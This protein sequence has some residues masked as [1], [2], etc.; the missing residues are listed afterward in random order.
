MLDGDL[1]GAGERV[2]TEDLARHRRAGAS[3]G[4]AGPRALV[5]GIVA[6]GPL[7]SVARVR[8]FAALDETR[9]PLPVGPPEQAM[10]D[11]FAHE[12]LDCYRLAVGV[13]RWAAEQVFPAHRR[14]LRDQLVRA[15]DSVVLNIAE[16]SGVGPGDARRNHHRIALGS[17]AEVAAILDITDLPDA[18]ARRTEIRRIGAMLA[19][20]QRR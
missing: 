3:G 19:V 4:A 1:V 10:S 8:G 15:A 12:G 17:A 5:P 9:A 11:E 13:S 2:L 20:L 14:H 18:Q 7:V 16:G 6:G